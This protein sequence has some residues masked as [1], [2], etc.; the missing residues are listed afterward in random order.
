MRIAYVILLAYAAK[1][2]KE[3]H[4][5]QVVGG[6]GAGTIAAQTHLQLKQVTNFRKC[7]EAVGLSCSPRPQRR[8]EPR[9]PRRYGQR[10]RR[11]P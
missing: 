6:K 1:V 2:L 8:H 7:R 4:E 5:S 11:P 3:L 10:N 9:R